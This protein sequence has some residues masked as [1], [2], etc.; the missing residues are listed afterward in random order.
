[1]AA[2]KLLQDD[3]AAGAGL[4]RRSLLKAAAAGGALLL[5]VEFA[6]DA[7]AA[8]DPAQ[9]TLNALIRIAADDVVTL[10]MPRVEMGQ[11]TYTSLSLLIA[12]ELEVDPA[13][14][15]LE[16]APPNDKLYGRPGW[17]IQVTGGSTSVSTSWLPLRQ[18]GAAARTM[19]V[20]AAAQVWGVEPE[21]CRAASGSVT[22]TASGRRLRYGALA[23]R[24]AQLPVPT[25]VALK[26]PEEFRRIG[27]KQL[28][29][30]APGK[31]N[32]K[33]RFGIDV[34]VP[35]MLV[36]TVAA[37]PVMGGRVR[38]LD[39]AAARRV[40]GVR[41]VVRLDDAVAV[42]AE[43]MAAARKGLAAANVQWNDGPAA[44][45][46]TERMAAELAEA[47][48]RPGATA[49]AQG[50]VAAARASGARHFD[51][52]YEQPL[53]AHAAMEPL[54]CTVH[55][56]ADA[57]EIWVG[58]QVPTRAQAAAAA[59]TGLPVDRIAVNNQL[60]GGSFGRR[61]DVDFITLAVRIGREVQGPVKVVWTREEDMQHDAYRPYHYNRLGATLDAQGRPT[62]WQHR[63]TGSSTLARWAPATYKN[64]VD[65]DAIRDAAGPYE[66]PN[67]LVQYVRQEPPAGLLTGFWR[68][69]GHTLNAF[70]VE[71]FLDELAHAAGTDPIAY[72]KGLLQ[73]HPRAQRVL[74][75]VAEKSGWGRA[76]N[77]GTG[78]GIAL[79]RCFG[80]YAAQVAEVSVN[81]DGA[82]RVERLVTVVDCG[83]VVSPRSVEAQ[84]QGG[85]VYGLTA[86]LYGNITLKNG[87]VE[88]SNF[89]DYPALRMN[90]MPALESHVVQSTDDPGGMGEVSTVLVAPAVG[91]AVFAATGKRIRRLPLAAGDLK[92]A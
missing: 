88:Q 17:G 69:V 26:R 73:K 21:G 62:A 9:T 51:A 60:I 67:L 18:A 87:R 70:P 42:V 4:T 46:S 72:R 78:R 64:E 74:D 83:M 23:A 54:N 36:A 7:A 33:A 34:V 90:E 13:R 49:R 32:G 24:A 6:L 2:G 10:V 30:D 16:H 14:V 50:D 38:E 77:K 47:S 65:S 66:F 15:R 58:T 12:E 71:S 25:Q 29:L 43:H 92:L 5:N 11:G 85:I 35:G 79:T 48:L 86:V 91:N 31:V 3:Q 75:L 82:L 45:Y 28:R 80:S 44:G 52:V 39:V 56:R 76:L 22:H 63:V 27:G 59:V 61:L 41:Q 89:H 68:G 53:M 8:A 81:A 84:I 20:A 37:S 19:L 57:C 1:M 55:V 40:R